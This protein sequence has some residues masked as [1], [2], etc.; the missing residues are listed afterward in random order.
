MTDAVLVAHKGRSQ[1]VKKVVN[2]LKK[3]QI[4]QAEEFPKDHRPWVGLKY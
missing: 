2:T 3:N 4:T 1:D